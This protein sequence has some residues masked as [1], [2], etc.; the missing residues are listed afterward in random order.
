MKRLVPVFVAVG[1]LSLMFAC[2]GGGGGSS[3]NNSSSSQT[4]L[5]GTIS[6]SSPA[7]GLKSGHAP[8]P[9]A[10]SV[11]AVPIAKMQGANIDSVNFVLRKTSVLDANGNFSFSLAKSISLSD[12]VAQ[13]PTLDTTG[14]DPNAVFAV[15]W[16]L[17]EMAGKI[18]LNVI[19]LKGD[20]SFDSMLTMPLSVFTPT[21]MNLGRV[22]SG[23]S[24]LGVSDIAGSV[25]LSTGSLK[26]IARSDKILKSI[27]D[28]IRNC[29]LTTN[30]CVSARQSFVFMGVYSSLT[31]TV[32]YDRADDYSGYQFSFD[33]TDYFASADF[34]GI[35]PAS[36]PV[37]VEYKLVPPAPIS[38]ETVT[39]SSSHPFSSGTVT[40][41]LSTIVSGTATY[42]ECFKSSY[43][44]YLR[45]NN[46]NTSDWSLQIIT[47]DQA[48][49]LTKATPAGDWILSRNSVTIGQFEFALANPIDASG[50]PIVF[51]PA[52]R[53]DVNAG[54]PTLTTLH[55]KWYQYQGISAGYVEITDAALLNTLIGKFEIAMD[56]FNGINTDS[57]RR[58]YHVSNN[59][60]STTSIDVSNPSDGKGPFLY[61]S[62]ST[63]NYNLD[64]LGVG[65]QFGGQNFRFA[66]RPIN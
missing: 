26:A 49:Q 8:A 48:S 27:K 6:S 11:W 35:C 44:L 24:S 43:P 60:F 17:V 12:I 16:L 40:G 50:N 2:G 57:S 55:I 47:G 20:A 51:V 59:S 13:V 53:F 64:Y 10:D 14:F 33:M 4:Q 58:S 32:N 31:N 52:V 28:I 39:Y 62:S 29:D 34:D 9:A 37:T 21:S 38:V 3:S 36:G 54:A 18:P 25:N 19:A 22:S 30:K 63:I 56:D 46:N 61:N 66:W 5:S 7:A 41:T 23:V 15:D 1:I 45:K 42:T 65:Y